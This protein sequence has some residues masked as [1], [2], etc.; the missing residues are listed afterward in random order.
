MAGRILPKIL[1]QE[2]TLGPGQEWDFGPFYSRPGRTLRIITQGVPIHYAGA[3]DAPVYQA[4]RAR[5]GR[6][7]FVIGTGRAGGTRSVYQTDQGG[8]FYIVVR[9]SGWNIG[10]WP[11][12]VTAEYG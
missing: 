12:R 2:V 8:P 1:E 9:V 4:F 10:R 5:G 11:I 6:A 3:F 7:P